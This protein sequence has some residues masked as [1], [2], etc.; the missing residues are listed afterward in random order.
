LIIVGCARRD[1]KDF[2]KLKN[3]KKLISRNLYK[4]KNV[5][6]T[7]KT[8]FFAYFI[9]SVKTKSKPVKKIRA[10]FPGMNNPMCQNLA[11]FERFQNGQKN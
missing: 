8:S 3:S 6:A 5:D 1:R 2:D 9:S 7:W 10:M 11:I 4:L